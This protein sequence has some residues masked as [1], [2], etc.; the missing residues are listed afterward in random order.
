MQFEDGIFFGTTL[1]L[2]RGHVSQATTGPAPQKPCEAEISRALL[3]AER[4]QPGL[5]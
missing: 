5:L 4:R 2:Q 1:S 3:P